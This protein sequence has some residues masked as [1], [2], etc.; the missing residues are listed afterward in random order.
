MGRIK[1]VD[2]WEAKFGRQMDFLREVQER[3]GYNVFE[4]ARARLSGKIPV[5]D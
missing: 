1:G 4:L 2:A 5:R 3:L